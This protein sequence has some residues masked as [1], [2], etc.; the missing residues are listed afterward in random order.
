MRIEASL[1]LAFSVFANYQ[2]YSADAIIV[3]D[4]QQTISDSL[5]YNAKRLKEL[6][7]SLYLRGINYDVLENAFSSPEFEVIKEKIDISH[8]NSFESKVVRKEMT[9]EEYMARHD[10]NLKITRGNKFMAENERQLLL[11]QERYSVPKEYITAIIG[12]ET[13]FLPFKYLG[14][15]KVFNVFASKFIFAKS[16]K[17]SIDELVSLFSL[18]SRLDRNVL[19]FKGSYA[20]A[21]G[22]GQFLP[23]SAVRY[24]VSSKDSSEI[25]IASIDDNIHSI[26]NYLV[27]NGWTGNSE[28]EY[29]ALYRYN[30]SDAYVKSVIYIAEHLKNVAKADTLKEK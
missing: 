13:A 17:R 22:Y 8:S 29:S 24:F 10:V 6:K 16:E 11:A 14:N 21:M 3:Q 5:T 7:D 2:A 30:R 25:D 4:T 18:S 26:A 9:L 23:S 19:S 1:L 28:D 20:G 15:F 12:M 27:K